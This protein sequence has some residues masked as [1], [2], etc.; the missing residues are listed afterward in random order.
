MA[1]AHGGAASPTADA[2]AGDPI[3]LLPR[4]STVRVRTIGTSRWPAQ[5]GMPRWP[6]LDIGMES[7]DRI[8]RRL[9][10]VLVDGNHRSGTVNNVPRAASTDG[11]N[12]VRP[13]SYIS[14][15]RV[16]PRTGAI[17]QA[18]L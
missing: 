10:V 11:V 13:P 4:D 8:Q 14:R 1:L 5:A 18:R 6:R 7:P 12:P 3:E 16:Q 2:V 15:M 9:D 17:R